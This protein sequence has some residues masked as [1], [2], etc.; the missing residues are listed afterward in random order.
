VHDAFGATTLEQGVHW[1]RDNT[2]PALKRFLEL[3]S[4]RY[5]RPLPKD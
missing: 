5:A 4:H 1:R 3:L 2:N